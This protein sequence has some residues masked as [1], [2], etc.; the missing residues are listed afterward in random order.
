MGLNVASA[1]NALVNRYEAGRA[2]SR[3]DERMLA[4]IGLTANDVSAAFSEPIWRD[5]TR[6][7]AVIAVE[8]RVA[9]RAARRIDLRQRE[10][11]KAVEL[12]ADC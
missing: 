9:A 10:K 2:L 4:D 6:R 11:T 7:L 3:F 8:R 5:P 12:V 1:I